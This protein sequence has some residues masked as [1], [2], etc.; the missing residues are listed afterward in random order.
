MENHERDTAV[1]WP[2][3]ILV[4]DDDRGLLK[5]MGDFLG[6]LGIVY[7]LARDGHD[8]IEVLKSAEFPLV[9]TDMD[10]PNVNGMQL[11]SHINAHYARTAV[12]AMTG[13]SDEYALADV[14]LA[15]AADYMIKPF[16]LDELKAKIKRVIR[17]RAL[18]QFM[19]QEVSARRFHERDLSQQKNSLLSQVQQQKEELLE[20]NAALRIIL[21]QRDM[22]KNDLADDLTSRFLKEILPY[23]EKL[24]R[25]RLQ[26]FQQQYLDIV[27]M[28]LENIFTPSAQSRTYRC[29]PFTSMEAKIV[30]L[31]KQGKKTKDIASILQ[32]SAGTIRTHRENIRKKLQITNTQKNLYK[33][34]I[35]IL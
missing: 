8:A 1:D 24:R 5:L 4:V 20:T 17:E 34:V 25:S 28:N 2:S 6:T 22:E 31:I 14:I 11:I 19:Q 15:G 16:T 13:Y 26:E 18:L 29:K 23:L 12:V 10:M 3:S 21:R 30:N 32:V 33:T 7:A 9:F 35:S 27:M